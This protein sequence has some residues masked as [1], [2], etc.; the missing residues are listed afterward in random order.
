MITA[1]AVSS[2]WLRS[3]ARVVCALAFV[4]AA[5]CSSDTGGGDMGVTT[6][7][8]MAILSSCGHPGDPGNSK[9][10]GKFCTSIADCT[11]GGRTTNICSALGNK[12]TPSPSDTYFCTIYPCHPDGGV[13]NECGENAACV[14]G[15]SGGNA[16][17]ACT[18]TACAH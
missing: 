9:G 7:G 6:G 15:S 2:S 16:G 14:C 8:D 10:V 12:A 3:V 18:P 13:S 4:T 5:A 11:G 17:C 1:C